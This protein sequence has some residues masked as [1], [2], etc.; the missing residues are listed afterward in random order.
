MRGSVRTGVSWVMTLV[1]TIGVLA[2]CGGS[3]AATSPTDDDAGTSAPATE[4]ATTA[5]ESPL[6]AG[7]Y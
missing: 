3:S 1:V 4:D 7:P 5:V 2:S 6:P